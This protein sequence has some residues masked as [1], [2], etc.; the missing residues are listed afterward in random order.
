[1]GS[2]FMQYFARGVFLGRFFGS[3]NASKWE[4]FGF[5]TACRARREATLSTSITAPR[6][7][8]FGLDNK[9]HI[10]AGQWPSDRL[11][12]ADAVRTQVIEPYAV[13]SGH[14]VVAELGL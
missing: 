12:F 2:H 6:A 3:K 1:M 11:Y 13:L 8:L 9:Q 4:A 10:I 5:P 14:Q 7:E